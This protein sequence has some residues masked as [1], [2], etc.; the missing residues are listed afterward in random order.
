MLRTI[1]DNY[2][3]IGFSAA[4]GTLAAGAQTGDIQI[5][6]NN[7]DWSNLNESN[8]YSFDPTKTSYAEWN[9]V[10]LFHNDKLVWGIEP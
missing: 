3:E 1:T 5:R 4:A 8:D 6:M 2:I 7:S 10:T 9:K